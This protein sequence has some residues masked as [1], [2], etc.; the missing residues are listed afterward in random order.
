[1]AAGELTVRTRGGGATNAGFR[2]GGRPSTSLRRR[3][4]GN[5]SAVG[6]A[7]GVDLL[8]VGLASFP[9]PLFF[10]FRL[11]ARFIYRGGDISLDAFASLRSLC[12][13]PPS[14]LSLPVRGPLL[15]LFFLCFLYF[16]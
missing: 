2:G 1:M 12:L 15:F 10:L 11:E 4:R 3:S 9:L 14:V 6:A 16:L 7:G 13:L 5:S 8:G